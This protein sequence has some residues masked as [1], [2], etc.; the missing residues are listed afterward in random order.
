MLEMFL[1]NKDGNVWD[2]SE[3][4]T[5]VT[6][7][8]SRIGKPGSLDFTLIKNSPFQSK[9]IKYNNG[10]IVTLRY[11][12]KN[13]F[14]GYVFKVDGGVSENVRIKCYDQMR[15]LMNVETYVFSNVTATQIIRHIA[16]DFNLQLGTVQD[17]QYLIPAMVEDGKKL[18]DI[19][20][21]ALA[22]TLIN[23]GQN[24]VLYDDYGSL[25]LRNIEDMLLDI[26]LGDNSLMHN[27]QF[28]QSID[29]DTFNRVKLYRD[30]E[31]T[32][33]RDVYIAQ[34]SANI[35]KWGT[36]QLYQQADDNMN[37]AQI[38]ELLNSLITIKNRE[39]K[40][41][42]LECIGDIT[43]RAGCYVPIVIEEYGINQP[44]VV[45]ECTHRWDGTD[46]QMSVTLKVV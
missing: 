42:K 6:W 30:N 11:N 22:L 1:D 12:N 17:T 9:A 36:L 24:F 16:N 23:S 13:I 2:I 46:H 19:L 5:G 27:Y 26:Y 32:G 29:S 15:Y 14:Y 31:E 20:D 25:S 4:V 40:D 7:K 3:I 8:T 34:D 10:D 33:K 37:E 18:I 45:D 35:A 28:K 41:L 21:K 44:F 38:N 39:T 43:V